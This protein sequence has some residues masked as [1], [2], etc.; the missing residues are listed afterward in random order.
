MTREGGFTLVEL[1][2]AAAL[3]ALLGALAWPALSSRLHEARRA[4][5]VAELTRLE[6]AQ[7]AF[8]AQHGTYAADLRALHGVGAVSREGFYRL[9][10]VQADAGRY[11]ALAVADPAGRQRDD[12]PCTV[13]SLQ[14]EAQRAER[15]PSAPC[16]LRR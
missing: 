8:H 9:A 14:V 2:V 16:W 10:I 5:A 4:D 15:G 12:T 6:L 11:H 13:I 1:M 3:A 7:A